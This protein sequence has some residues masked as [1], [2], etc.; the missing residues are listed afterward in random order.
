[1]LL[2]PVGLAAVELGL[3]LLDV[4]GQGAFARLQLLRERRAFLLPRLEPLLAHLE[5]GFELRLLEVEL[6]LALL[7]L[8]EPAVDRR[9]A[10]RQLVLRVLRAARR[11]GRQR[12]V[13]PQPRFAGGELLLARPEPAVGE[14]VDLR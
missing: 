9:L 11:G 14:L 3:E 8:V 2:P 13:L 4:D 1:L 12:L 7:E 10:Q 5:L 6:L